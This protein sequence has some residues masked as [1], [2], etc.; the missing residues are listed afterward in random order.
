MSDP[1][2]PTEEAEYYQ[3]RYWAEVDLDPFQPLHETVHR[4]VVGP[5]E[6]LSRLAWG[7]SPLAAVLMEEAMAVGKRLSRESTG[8]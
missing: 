3:L 4:I 6:F 1:D 5:D 8:G 7:E 2:S